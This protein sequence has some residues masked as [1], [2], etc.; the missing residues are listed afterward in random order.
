MARSGLF[1]LG[2]KDQV[3]CF[4]CN[5]E[6]HG[7]N[8]TNK[9]DEEHAKHSP[10]CNFLISKV[11]SE[12]IA[13]VQAKKKKYESKK[14]SQIVESMPCPLVTHKSIEQEIILQNQSIHP[15]YAS[16]KAR[17]A[18]FN[19]DNEHHT[20]WPYKNTRNLAIDIMVSAGFFF[21]GKNYDQV[22]C[23]HCGQQFCEWLLD[24]NP[25]Q[26]HLNFSSCCEYIKQSIGCSAPQKIN[27][28]ESKKQTSHD[29]PSAQLTDKSLAA[30]TTDT[31]PE[32]RACSNSK[33]E[34]V[35]QPQQWLSSQG[36]E[37]CS[38]SE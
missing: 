30:K 29:T 10:H 6:I 11:R 35:P 18:T 9:P 7:W 31:K 19:G 1:F 38:P 23:F 8:P 33:E 3:I 5:C 20:P 13:D 24:S 25:Y 26:A 22:D 27:V 32:D 36:H 2:L 21:T 15:L 37:I 4:S 34:A 28:E 12:F 16:S 17:K 14:K